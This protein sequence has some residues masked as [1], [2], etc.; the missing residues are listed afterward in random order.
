MSVVNWDIVFGPRSSTT[1]TDGSFVPRLGPDEE[2][3]SNRS[4]ASRATADL[5]LYL[6]QVRAERHNRYC[7]NPPFRCPTFEAR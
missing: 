3:Q 2:H 5:C 7:T 6:N 4:L 1:A